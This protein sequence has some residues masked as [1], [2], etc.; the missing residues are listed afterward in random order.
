MLNMMSRGKL[1]RVLFLITLAS[2]LMMGESAHAQSVNAFQLNGTLTDADGTALVGYTVEAPIAVSILASASITDADGKYAIL[3]SGFEPVATVGDV[4]EI[5]VKDPAGNIVGTTSY[6]V[7]EGDIGA[8]IGEATH[9]ILLSGLNVELDNIQLPADG[10]SQAEIT[11][12]IES[13]DGPVIGDTVTI[14]ADMGSVGEVTDN[15]DGTYTAVY[16]APALVIDESTSDTINVSSDTTG[17]TT[18]TTVTLE[19]VPTVIALSVEPNVFT[20]GAGGTGAIAI[21]VSR[22]G[23]A[24]ADAELSLGLTRAGG[25][26][27]TGT[28][29]GVTSNGDGTYNATFTAPNTT[30]QIDVTA[31]DAVS[32]RSGMASVNVNAGP[33]ATI[34]VTAAPTSVSSTGSAVITAAV[35]DASGNGVGGLALSGSAES[36][37]VGEFSAGSAFGRY[38]ATYTAG[39]VEAEGTDTVTVSVG[40]LSGQ[41][42]INL[43]PVPPKEVEILV[44]SG[45]VYKEDGTG[46]VSG[47][48]VEVTV[49]DM[50]PKTTVTDGNGNYSVT[51]FNP[52]GVAGSTGDMVTIVVTDDAGMERG[53]DE[54]VLTNED[55]GDD[56][57][58]NV[59]RDVNTDIVA[60]TSALAVTG[61]VFRE[62]SEIPIDDVFAITVMS[63]TRGTEVTGMTDENGMYN[64]TFFGTQ[65]VAETG[66]E[67]VVTASRDGSE[68]SSPAHSLSSEEVEAGRAMVNVP[69]DIKAST[70]ALAVTGTVYFEDGTV[71]VGAGVTVTS[72]NPGRGLETTSTTDA[73]GKYS[74]TFFSAAGLVAET[75]DMIS[76]T[77]VHDGEAVGTTER[78]LTS[79]EVDAQRAEVDVVTSVKASTSTLVVTG[80]AYY[81][82][83]MIP[84]G[85]GNTVT[86]VNNAN[87]MEASGM[88]DA[89]GMYN[90]TIFS[91]GATVAETGDMLTITVTSEADGSGTLDYSLTAMEIDAQRAMVDVPTNIKATSSAFVVSGTVY[92]EDGIS[93]APAG[94]TVKVMNETQGINVEGW[95]VPGGGY[96]VTF[97]ATETD[98]VKTADEL[99]FDVLVM[100]DDETPVGQTS[101]TLTSADVVAQRIGGIDITTSLTADPTNAFVVDGTVR[102]PSD[103]IVSSGVR[104]RV[105]L[106]DH[107]PMEL[108]TNASG[109]YTATYFDLAVPVAS[110][111]DTVMIAAVDYS[112]GSAMFETMQLASHHVLAQR[113]MINV[114]LIPDDE[115]PVAVAA[116]SQRFLDPNEDSTFDASGST[117][118]VFID[119]YVWNYGDGTSGSGVKTTHAYDRAGLYVVTLT[120]TDLARNA[121]TV[122]REI[123]VS[124][125]RLG[126]IS[127][128]T[129]HAREVLDQIIGLAI[130]KTD[131]AQQMGTEQFLQM[132]R[133]NPAIQAAVAEAI[134]GALPPGLI[135]MQL[136]ADNLP[137]IF[138]QYENIDLENFGNAVTARVDAS[139]GL[140][141]SATPGYGRVVTGE[142]LDLYLATPRADVGSV[143]FRFDEVTTDA[144]EV[145]DGLPH[146]FQ[147][148]EEQAILL[149]PSW[150]GVR[151][152]MDGVFSSVTLMLASEELPSAYHNLISRNAWSFRETSD[153]QAASMSPRTINGKI[154]WDVQADI[155]PGK[156]YYYYYAVELAYPV[157]LNL[158]EGQE[159]MEL[160]QYAFPDPRNLQ[161][162]DRGLVEAV[163]TPELQ[164]AIAPLLN[165]ILSGINSGQV[166]TFEDVMASVTPEVWVNL[167]GA[168]LNSATPLLEEISQTMDTQLIS[169]FT[170][171]LVNEAQSLWHTSIDLS[172]FPDGVHTIDANAFDSLGIQID[173][174]PVFGKTFTLDRT[175][176]VYDVAAAPGQNSSMYMRD[177]GVL[178]A[179]GL[180]PAGEGSPMATLQLM[181]SANGDVSDAVEGLYQIIRHSDDAVEQGSQTWVNIFA[182]EM[183]PMFQGLTP[184]DI[185]TFLV[186]FPNLLSLNAPVIINGMVAEP[187]VAEQMEMLI[188]GANSSPELILGEYG[189]RVVARDSVFNMSTDTAPIRLNIVPPDPDT[190]MVV[191]ISLGDCN[192]DGDTDDLYETGAPADMILFSDTPNVVLTAE[193]MKQVHPI[194]SILFQYRMGDEGEWQDVGTLDAEMV[195]G[196]AVGSQ[197][198][199]AWSIDN[200]G[201]LI[202]AGMP[203]MVRAVVTNALS[204]SDTEA[205]EAAIAV[206]DHPCPIEPVIHDLAHSVTD[207]NPDSNAP[208]GAIM[209]QAIT[210][211]LTSPPSMSVVFEV[212]RG[213]EWMSVGEAAIADSV[214]EESIVDALEEALEEVI[215]GEQ[216]AVLV[217]TR[218]VWSF[219][220][221]STTL[222]DTISVG[223]PAERDVTLDENPYV[224]R[225]AAVDENGTRYESVEALSQ[226]FS[227][228]NIDDVPPLTGTAILQ[229]ADAA[230]VIEAMESI[231]TVGGIVDESVDA[232]VAMVMS[233]PI[234][235]PKTYSRVDLLINRRNDDGSLGDAVVETAFEMG[236]ENYTTTADVS[237][238]EN[239]AYLFQALAMDEVGNQE[240]R[241]LVLAISVDVANFIP[242]PDIDLNGQTVEA[243]TEAYPDGFPISRTY[244]FAVTGIALN[245]GD[246]DVLVDGRSANELGALTVTTVEEGASSTFM[247]AIDT[248]LLEEGLHA[249]D[250]QVTKRNGSITFVLA[251]LFVDNA[252]PELALTSPIANDEVSALPSIHAVYNDGAGAGIE[253]STVSMSM[254]RLT[255]PDM[256]AVEIDA[257]QVMTDLTDLVHTRRDMLPAGV[258]RV[259]VTVSDIVDNVSNMS[260][261]FTVV[262]TLP[263]VSIL[264]PMPGQILDVSSPYISAVYTGIG[265]SITSF[266]LDG[267]DIADATMSDNR[268]EYTPDALPDGDHT[269]AIAITDAEGN[270]MSDSVK[271]TVRTADTTPP[272]ITEASPQGIVKSAS[273]TLS[274]AASDE[275]SGIGSVSYAIDDGAAVDGTTRN[276]SDLAPGTHTVAAVVTNGAGLQ[277]TFNWT[278]TV[279]LDT[280]PPVISTVA[281]QG[282]IKEASTTVSAAIGDEQSSVTRITMS[283][284]GAAARTASLQDGR[285]SRVVSDLTP[286]THSVTVSATSAGGTGTHTWRFTVELDT[287]PPV[288]TRARP[289]GVITST[290]VTIAAVVTDEE[291]D[292]T[293]VTIALD[294]GRAT[295]VTPAANG[296][297]N[298]RVTDLN[299]GL[300]GIEL[301]AT[302]AGG[303][304][305]HTWTFNVD[306]DTTPPEVSSTSPHGIVSVEQPQISVA[307][308]DDRGGILAIDITLKDS[309]GKELSGRTAA[310]SDTTSATFTPSGRLTGGT[311]SVDATVKDRSQNTASASWSF[312]V[313]FD[314]VPP[315]I[316]VVAP[317]GESRIGEERRPII[318]A[319]YTDNAAGVDADSVV[320]MLDGNPVVP[321]AVSTSQVVYTPPAD[322]DFGRHTVRLEVSD[323]AAPNVN[324]AIHEW[325]FVLEDGKG[326]VFRGV[327]RNYPNPFK[328]NTKVSFTLARESTVSIEIY[329][330]TGRLVRVLAQDEVREAGGNEFPW[331]GKTSTGD[332]L[333]R[334]VYFGQIMVTSEPTPEFIVVRMALL[335]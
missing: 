125:V 224:L 67:I 174:R 33:A 157:T 41:A 286:G 319:S 211:E 96:V 295:D 187:M 318:T 261:D 178:I 27:D 29:T 182:S 246:I 13:G 306:L 213:E 237:T 14:T 68:W 209:L 171:P 324:T 113:L 296:P 316:T 180:P 45:T 202:Q 135:P 42:T 181:S 244:E 37:T 238:L 161:I 199:V 57:A 153:Y 251:P 85:A 266:T 164:E 193:I 191:R 249:L 61:S 28:V 137:L 90:V 26:A 8:R 141:G 89:N 260:V 100:A 110:V 273:A 243:V 309:D 194:S 91:P 99:T 108:Q 63:T 223:D 268:L 252:A 30:G 12:S 43:T 82:G 170:V 166:V 163:F 10:E 329:D 128:N 131:I 136:L 47:V 142:K 189:L 168:A 92:L 18:T 38:S 11:V 81:E 294:G 60:R 9:N 312:T 139:G 195:A 233:M 320:L 51:I 83:S 301:V 155:E 147:L 227:V 298:R 270:T 134:G 271:F 2:G 222:E 297:V 304:A 44:I 64:L 132:L 87:G 230:G 335:R 210:R 101:L 183:A 305:T 325:S 219:E 334:G 120:V 35:A 5:T 307:A 228:D 328:D 76:V 303:T 173:N 162:Q 165:P 217:P 283:V 52:G 332:V 144:N 231:F 247:L 49:G 239:G 250:L 116:V 285:A 24:V 203:V 300:H 119:T 234:A 192:G 190:A 177:D 74:V 104:V 198:D 323:L 143:T 176:P 152:G 86:V 39:T 259:S 46:P 330:I 53:R 130:A 34:T 299:P 214:V 70:S 220:L 212:M 40:D 16:T 288:I 17:D 284:D 175:A 138:E 55:L 167:L 311:Y 150:P 56:T 208:R 327:L 272:L 159:S 36:G 241:D 314:T 322:L 257:S 326:P 112:T 80:T 269:A 97:L 264:S 232:P 277:S 290:S 185:A 255:P 226:S 292:V 73:D 274:V 200:L 302:S 19:P 123:F 98:A 172:V 333:A 313:E 115:P 229:V 262:T 308:S 293:S 77:A 79:A 23:N 236:E 282:V 287:T 151:G 331:D 122:S 105:T 225:A 88:T 69:T 256:S 245:A 102:D 221:D 254:V 184:G 206:K 121:T 310:S 267:A 240:V 279:E 215:D 6:T 15:G 248:T 235:D 317:Q 186:T 281:P 197:Y 20:A 201:G 263:S 65:V 25:G 103:N 127:L 62:E 3:Y 4:I 129:R 71:A 94:L 7:T 145:I 32:G 205:G 278:F 22:G 289:Q 321:T 59:D 114:M 154:V 109:R 72:M 124:T 111:Y 78:A 188:R 275:E 93:G 148:E 169:V 158:G 117:D 258:Y 21:S 106:G 276:V 242:P 48:N 280:T 50:P 253:L 265:A 315:S 204:I 107:A 179:T 95:T 118:N 216:S 146:T 291:S 31:T 156:I 58:A 54:S 149:L 140:L 160:S 1:V 196:A 133:A 84:V 126:G 75:A 66:D 207:R 218:R